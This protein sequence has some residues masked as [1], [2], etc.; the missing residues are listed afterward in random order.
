MIQAIL[1]K[2]TILAVVDIVA[3]A[4]LIYQV[5]LVVRGRQ[6]AHILTGLSVL[7]VL[8]LLAVRFRLELLATV[9]ATLAPYSVIAL[10]V[11]FQGEIRSVLAR[12][13]RF[14]WLGLGSQLER[15]EIAEEI[16]LAVL[17][18]AE[19]RIGVLIVVEREIGLR[20]FIESGVAMDALVSRDLLCTI[21]Q[22]GAALHD[23]AAIIQG[24]RVAAAACFLPLTGNPA[25]SRR[26]GTRHRAAIGV[27]EESDAL[28]IVVSEET[29]QISIAL[30]GDLEQD[31]SPKRLQGRLTRLTLH[32][33]ASDPPAEL[34][35]PNTAEAGDSPAKIPAKIKV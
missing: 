22:R 32:R 16:A 26:L 27:T 33:R 25:L 18:M 20:T 17:Q 24:D 13:G 34:D 23:G 2:L 1:S 6:V 31:V 19:A 11:M 8:Y 4:I 30:R 15:R 10:I 3:M 9:L 29:G 28:A 7:V 35:L 12:I 14:R 5:V 21:F